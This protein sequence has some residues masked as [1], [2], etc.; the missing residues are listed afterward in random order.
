[1]KDGTTVVDA[2]TSAIPEDHPRKHS[3]SLG[4][5]HWRAWPLDNVF[6]GRRYLGVYPSNLPPI[7]RK[8]GGF[9]RWLFPASGATEDVLR[10][11][12]ELGAYD[13]P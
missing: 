4:E 9:I 1:M 13:R 2:T 10:A 3:F 7:G 6:I 5:Y 12:K 11:L 8:E